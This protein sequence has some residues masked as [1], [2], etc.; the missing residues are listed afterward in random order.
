MF[1]LSPSIATHYICYLFHY[2]ATGHYSYVT[3]LKLLHKI[4]KDKFEFQKHK[5]V[6]KGLS[7][8]PL[9][10]ELF[11]AD[12]QNSNV[13]VLSA[14]ETDARTVIAYRSKKPETP[15]AVCFM[16]TTKT[17]LICDYKDIKY[18]S[19][20]PAEFSLVALSLVGQQWIEQSRIHLAVAVAGK[21]INYFKRLC[22]LE[23][24]EFLFGV[25]NSTTLWRM[26]VGPTQQLQMVAEIIVPDDYYYYDMAA[27]AS[28]DSIRVALTLVTQS[29]VLYSLVGDQLRFLSSVPINNCPYAYVLWMSER[30]LVAEKNK[31]TDL[32]SV[33]ELDLTA[34]RLA[35]RA[36]LLPEAAGVALMRWCTEGLTLTIWDWK[37][38]GIKAFKYIND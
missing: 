26:R 9:T 21:G 1:I 11:L 23:D 10:G 36:E 32:F 33:W 18:K 27:I 20:A 12:A 30:F 34:N 24:S 16:R 29:L 22:E 38:G 37:F 14:M 3:H 5:P 6:I 31:E 28:N 15:I 7:T 13:I 4:P 19:E 2:V 8:N 25:E 17:L 35:R